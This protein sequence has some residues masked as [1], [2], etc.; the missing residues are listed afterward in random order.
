MDIMMP[1]LE[2]QPSPAPWLVRRN[3]V[4]VRHLVRAALE[5]NPGA[6]VDEVVAQLARWNV[7]AS[8]IIVAMWFTKWHES[9]AAVRENG[10]TLSLVNERNKNPS[11]QSGEP[12]WASTI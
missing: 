12:Q 5:Q 1:R 8:G 6:T 4:D 11:S 2:Q 3:S 9:S 10:R 7:Q